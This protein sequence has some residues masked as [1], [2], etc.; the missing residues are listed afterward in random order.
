MDSFFIDVPFDSM[1]SVTQRAGAYESLVDP[2]LHRQIM[3]DMI[4]RVSREK[5]KNSRLFSTRRPQRRHCTASISACRSNDET[6][7][8][9]AFQPFHALSR[10]PFTP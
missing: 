5:N 10:S 6:H 3:R 9:K 4:Y 1:S 8:S 2:L 7:A